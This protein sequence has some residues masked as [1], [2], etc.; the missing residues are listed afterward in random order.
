[1]A[2]RRNNDPND[3][4]NRVHQRPEHDQEQD[5]DQEK[6]QNQEKETETSRAHNQ[7]GNAA[8]AAMLN[9]RAGQDGQG[10]D[11]EAGGSGHSVRPR[12]AHEK[13]G[14]DYGGDD[15]VDDVPITLDDLTRSWN[16]GTRKSD[17]RPKFVEP[18]PDDDLPPEDAE[19]LEAVAD[20]PTSGPLP[21]IDNLDALLQPSA[22]VIAAST[23]G[24][25][26]AASRWAS[27]TPGWRGV[28]ALVASN[29]PVLQCA[30]ARVLPARAAV[31]ALGSCLLAESP[32][33]RRAPSLETGALIECC[34]ELEGR[35]HRTRNLIVELEG[36]AT[37][38]PRA[39]DLI[40]AH[41]PGGGSVRIRELPPTVLGPLTEALQQV[42]RWQSVEATLPRLDDVPD[43]QEDPDDP[44]GLDAVFDD[45]L[46]EVDREQGV[47]QTALQTAERMAT[48]GSMTRIEFAALCRVVDDV[49]RLWSRSPGASLRAVGSRLDEEIDGLLRLLL[50]VARAV[51]K[52]RFPPPKIRNGLIR[53]ARLLDTRRG[54]AVE[55]LARVCGALLPG[56]PE[57]PERPRLRPDPLSE[58][59]DMGVPLEA[60]PWCDALPRS[61]DTDLLRCCLRSLAGTDPS[62]ERAA[63]DG[64]RT[65]LIR[66]GR[67]GTELTVATIVLAHACLRDGD[68]D[69]VHVHASA[70]RAV[71]RKRRNGLL[72]AEGALLSMEA[73]VADDD[74]DRAQE[75]RLEAGR[76][77]WDLG[78]RGALSL[79]ARW[80]PPEEEAEDFAPFFD[81]AWEVEEE[82]EEE[83][84][85]DG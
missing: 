58:A 25:A 39:G 62:A 21:R 20:A 13:E 67:V 4:S 16:P 44:L 2:N 32:A 27:P 19:F 72:V 64:L 11:G 51:Q 60:M 17:D 45:V 9:A 73:C 59:L 37:K 71:G 50:D 30:D 63:W 28:A 46:G 23:A 83:G 31:G 81:Y 57:L 68:T 82:D 77:C 48:A 61:T 69:A 43:K 7:M 35:A 34:L 66:E 76:L 26:R 14:Q 54:E 55:V 52:R 85:E 53:G 42:I 75:I 22:E 18:M 33:V 65:A 1:M 6:E 74:E 12:K 38:L 3:L 84:D 56:I 24:W 49:A 70:L 10:M 80:S 15:V 40:A 5:Q 79:L 8:L 47:Y 29:A 36:T 41:I 78:A